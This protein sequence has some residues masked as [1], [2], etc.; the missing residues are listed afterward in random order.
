MVRLKTFISSTPINTRRINPLTQTLC[1][2][3]SAST[4]FPAL[5]T[6]SSDC[7][8]LAKM[9]VGSY[10]FL[11]IA[12]AISSLN[13]RVNLV[14]VALESTTSETDGNFPLSPSYRPLPVF[15]FLLNWMIF[16]KLWHWWLFWVVSQDRFCAVRIIDESHSTGIHVH[17]FLETSKEL[18]LVKN[19]GD[20]LLVSNVL[21][22]SS[23]ALLS[24]FLM[25]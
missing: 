6:D 5:S 17:F 22:N 13:Q 2:S 7:C 19:V 18:P 20:I 1:N 3:N 14:G 8:F 23:L 24:Y 15:K 9:S 16:R 10:K 25:W 4:R 21:V 11:Q 12:D